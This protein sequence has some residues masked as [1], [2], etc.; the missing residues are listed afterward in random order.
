MGREPSEH[1]GPGPAVEPVDARAEDLDVGANVRDGDPVTSGYARGGP[2][3]S[4]EMRQSDPV[5]TDPDDP[6]PSL[7]FNR[8]TC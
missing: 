4:L 6:A 2:S 3:Q 5:P 1:R 7:T 8:V